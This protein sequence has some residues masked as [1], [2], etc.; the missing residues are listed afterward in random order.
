MP[1]FVFVLRKDLIIRS[2]SAD[3]SLLILESKWWMNAWNICFSFNATFNI[4][5]MSSTHYNLCYSQPSC[6]LIGNVNDSLLASFAHGIPSWRV[7][8]TSPHFSP[9]IFLTPLLICIRD[10][11]PDITARS[12]RLSRTIFAEQKWSCISSR[13]HSMMSCQSANV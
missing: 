1:Y 5:N 10:V 11:K 12:K 3:D 9:F 13:L 2:T 4:E 6:I 8:V 7:L